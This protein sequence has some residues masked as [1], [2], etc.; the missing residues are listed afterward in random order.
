MCVSDGNISVRIRYNHNE[1][2]VKNSSPEG[3]L[4]LQLAVPE[5]LG[6]Y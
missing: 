3:V 4:K 1:M 5:L 2:R 6:P